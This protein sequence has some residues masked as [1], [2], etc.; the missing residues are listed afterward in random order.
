MC[1]HNALGVMLWE[2]ED[3][4]VMERNAAPVFVEDKER[5]FNNK[6]NGYMNRYQ[7]FVSL[8]DVSRN[9]TIWYTGTPPK[10]QKF[11]LYSDSR[12]PGSL[13]TLRYIDAGAYKLYHE[14]K[15]LAIPTDWDHDIENWAVPTGKYCCENRFIGVY[16]I[17]EF[18][19]KPG[20]TCY[21]RPRDAIML[22]I[23]L[24]W[25]VKAFFQ[26]GGIGKFT[27]R[28]AASLGIHK[29][30]LK[31]VQVY[32]GSVIVDFQV[33]TSEGD[34][35]PTTTLQ[36]L[37]QKLKD[38]APSLGDTLGAPVMQVQGSDGSVSAMP[39]YEEEVY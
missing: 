24:E 20:C 10:K 12:E 16:N 19:L 5:G 25:T 35:D 3:D 23:R 29:A 38:I 15:T 6:V 14:D 2:S 17:L 31:V 32:E 30:D 33:L 9:Y 13:I 22:A 11:T 1:Q 34:P 36:G 27:D 18:W 28:M 21:V 39:G 8:I 37:E 7:R 4:D 26:E